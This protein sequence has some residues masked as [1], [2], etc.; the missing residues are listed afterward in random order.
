MTAWLWSRARSTCPAY[1]ALSSKNATVKPDGV[2]YLDMG[3]GNG[4]AARWICKQSK[5][6][7]ITCID[8]CA[9]QS[10]ENR[11]LSDELGLG[12]Q[13]DVVQGT[14]ERL[15]S[16]YSNWFDG[17]MS[18][19]AFIHAYTKRNAFM[20]AFRVTKGGGW[21]LISDLMR[22]DGKDGDEEMEVFVKEHNITNWATPNECVQ[23]ATEAGWSEVRFIDCTAEIVV[24]LHGL[25]KKI[26]TMMDSGDYEGR[27]L[28]LLQTHRSRL[29]NRIG[30][31]D[32]GIFKWGII[33]GRKP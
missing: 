2:R 8:V 7:H 23:F 22:G 32:R 17:C 20:E 14:Y 3:A 16:D 10:C 4:A 15:N 28:K 1:R 33:S 19:D 27:N 13:I 11:N 6:I 29:T 30:L 9:K 18:Q 5:K 12:S 21:I 26:K 25:L 24:S 31:A